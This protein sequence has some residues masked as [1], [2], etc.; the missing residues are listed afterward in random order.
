MN[1][2]TVIIEKDLKEQLAFQC[3]HSVK[4]YARKRQEN[5]KSRELSTLLKNF[6]SNT[7]FTYSFGLH[8][9]ILFAYE[10]EQIKQKVINKEFN[11]E[12]ISHEE[13]WKEKGFNID[14]E[15]AIFFIYTY[16]TELY[17][18]TK[19]DIEWISEQMENGGYILDLVKD[20]IRTANEE[21]DNP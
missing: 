15:E 3:V 12:H 9:S 11:L 2:D 18:R 5:T 20:R 8:L 1:Q 16:F 21:M 10:Y 4:K 13:Y 17:P 14:T 19:K 7:E 6:I